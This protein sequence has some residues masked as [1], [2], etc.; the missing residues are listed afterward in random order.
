MAKQGKM[1]IWLTLWGGR[2]LWQGRAP[3]GAVL[4]SCLDICFLTWW[5]WLHRHSVFFKLWVL[6][7]PLSAYSNQLLSIHTCW[8]VSGASAVALGALG[9]LQRQVSP[10]PSLT[11][12]RPS[13]PL[14]A[15]PS[16]LSEQATRGWNRASPGI[17]QAWG[18]GAA[19]SILP[20]CGGQQC[21]LGGD[22]ASRMTCPCPPTWSQHPMLRDQ[23]QWPTHQARSSPALPVL[24]RTYQPPEAPGPA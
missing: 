13:L 15:L 4:G 1:G 12:L 22:R 17:Q 8:A 18:R 20:G 23:P 19:G 24:L 14:H 7:I 16:N 2:Q 9:G 11:F 3:W 5:W 10:E 21:R 6:Y